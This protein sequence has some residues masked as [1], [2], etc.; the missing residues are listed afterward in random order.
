LDFR[1]AVRNFLFVCK[2]RIFFCSR[3]FSKEVILLWDWEHEAYFSKLVTG[4]VTITSRLYSLITKLSTLSLFGGIWGQHFI[5]VTNA[6]LSYSVGATYV[7]SLC[8]FKNKSLF[9]KLA[10]LSVKGSLVNVIRNCLAIQLR[11]A[12]NYPQIIY[13]KTYLKLYW[14]VLALEQN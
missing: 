1:Q 10:S 11:S 5:S 3:V 9:I 7:I 14:I 2:S 8:N 4:R 12:Y 6:H 13:F